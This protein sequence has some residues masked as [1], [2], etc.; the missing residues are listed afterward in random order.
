VLQL[1]T[2]HANVET[3]EALKRLETYT[4][5]LRQIRQSVAYDEPES[6]LN[7]PGDEEQLKQVNDVV[8][9]K[10]T[11]ALKYSVVVGIG[12]SSQGAKAVYD[13][14]FGA[15]D[16]LEPTRFPKMLFA[17]TTDPEWLAQTARLLSSLSAP[18]E[19]LV[20]VISKSGGTTETLANFEI[21]MHALREKFG[22]ASEERVVTITD[23]GS[24]LWEVAGAKGIV[25]LA[26][27]AP[28]GG[29]YSV[30]SAVGL[31]PLASVGIDIGQLRQGAND[32]LD[33]TLG[34]DDIAA[35]SA[36]Q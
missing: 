32:M 30:L 33:R 24:K 9:Q 6:S 21:I 11:P 14:L 15:R 1:K 2:E 26:I 17:E 5:R 36:A 3:G 34:E 4:E 25:R 16:V 28:V 23:E 31:L 12:G 22:Q 8:S 29:R 10:V 19:V 7:L 18:E 35:H 13:A 20:T 27:P